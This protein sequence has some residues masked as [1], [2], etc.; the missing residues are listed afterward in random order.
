MNTQQAKFILQGYRSNGADAGDATFAEALDHVRHD[1]ELASW[2]AKG[3]AFDHAISDKLN[4]VQPPVGLREAILAG[5]RVTVAE[6]NATKQWWRK[7]V[8]LAMAASVTL[9]AA[10]G[11]VFWPKT[12]VANGSLNDF[13]LADSTSLH[14]HGDSGPLAAALRE[15]LSQPT[16]ALGQ[17]RP[18]DYKALR[19]SGCRT[20]KFQGHEIVEICF[21]RDGLWF[22]CYIAQ[23]EDFPTLAAALAPTLFEQG[24]AAIASWADATHLYLVVSK[25]GRT[26]LTEIL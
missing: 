10:L 19:E 3:T 26:A 15:T 7:P 5:G 12:A 4:S 25:S 2:L 11:L 1:S 18:V 8:W 13:V 21:K 24:R 6:K 22:H 14:G 23:R 9:F 16:T 20:V 17:M